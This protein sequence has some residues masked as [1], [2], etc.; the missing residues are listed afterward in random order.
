MFLD[1]KIANPN[2]QKA[3]K[4]QQQQPGQGPKNQQQKGPQKTTGK[5][6]QNKS[7]PAPQPLNLFNMTKNTPP[8]P[9]SKFATQAN[10]TPLGGLVIFFKLEKC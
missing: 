7:M 5:S 2:M 1:V 8:K 6:F 10:K 3:M 9:G 4:G